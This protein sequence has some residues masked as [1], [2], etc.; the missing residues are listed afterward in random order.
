MIVRACG[1]GCG[2]A[3]EIE[4]KKE[5]PKKYD[6]MV[7]LS[8]PEPQRTLLEEKLEIELQNYNG[9]IIFVK[10]KIKQGE[11]IISKILIV[12]KISL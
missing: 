11:D 9:Q 8:G 7:I 6:L 12:P 3:L 2:C 10:G 5:V 4:I 1:C